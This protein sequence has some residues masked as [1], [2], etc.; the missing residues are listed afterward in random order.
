LHRHDGHGERLVGI[1]VDAN[2]GDI[3]A[4]AT[5]GLDLFESNV[6]AERGLD[7]V[8]L[9]VDDLQTTILEPLTNV[10]G[11]EPTIRATRLGEGFTSCSFKLP[12]ALQ[13]QTRHSDNNNDNSNDNNNDNNEIQVQI[14][15]HSE[16]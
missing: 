9:A 3:R 5:D 15:Q 1:G 13:N 11:A 12:I 4:V 2:V 10:S 8:L 16:I 7:E 14:S 6:L